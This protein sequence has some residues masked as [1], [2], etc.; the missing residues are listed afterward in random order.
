MNS[1]SPR[2]AQRALL[3]VG[4]VL[5][6]G[7]TACG[8]DTEVEQGAAAAFDP[9]KKY[10]ITFES[11]N[12]GNATWDKPIRSLI[13]KFEAEHPNVTVKAQAAGGSTAA[14]GTAS[15]VQRQVLAGDPPDVVQ[16]TFDTLGYA[17]SD[18]QAK[19]LD[20]VFGQDALDEHFGGEHPVHE[21]VRNFGEV[22]GHVYGVP[23]VL[24]TP[25]MYYNKTALAEA[26][27]T[28]PDFSTWDSVAEIAEKMSAETGTPSF[29]NSCL[30]PIGEWCYQSM[31]RSAGGQVLSDDRTTIQAGEAEAVAPIA[32]MQE[33]F[34]AG[35]LQNADFNGQYEAFA[36]GKTQMHLNSASMQGAFEAGA[37]SGGWELGAAPMP[38]FGDE[39]VVPVSS[40]SM[41]SVFTPESDV[42]A[43]AWEFVKFMTSE[44]A[45]ETISPMGYLPLRT[46]MAQEGGSLADWAAE[47]AD[48][49][50]PNLEQLDEIEP[51]VS[52]PGDDYV[53]IATVVMD[54]VEEV[55]YH[56][57]DPQKTLGAAQ[58]RA[59]E[60]TE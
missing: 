46:S 57:A 45:Y 2:R 40:G 34:E 25:I 55:V 29:G 50:R 38:A 37:A 52:Y 8:S 42:Q 19:P 56:G 33:L 5:A 18:L 39:P 36:A 26:G 54:A 58:E 49:L 14:G 60:L 12:L 21:K 1:R 6:L 24:S 11:Y 17:V 20:E 32:R 43:A 30:D 7:L 31:V 41:L 13:D 10:E 44:T 4:A 59:Q 51:W 3:A 15:S 53:Q 35:A 23:Y 16:L 27:I 28:D 9:D 48:L 47:Q 22:D